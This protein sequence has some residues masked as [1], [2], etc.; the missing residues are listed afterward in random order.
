MRIKSIFSLLV[1][2]L[3]GCT[4]AVAANDTPDTASI[5]GIATFKSNGVNLRQ[6]P[7]AY[8]AYLAYLLS[9][10]QL[11]FDADNVIWSTELGATRVDGQTII[12]PHDKMQAYEGQTMPVIGSEGDW[13]KLRYLGHDVWAMNKFL[14]IQP[15][16]APTTA[17]TAGYGNYNQFCLTGDADGSLAVFYQEGGMDEDPGLLIGKKQGNA[18]VFDYF[19]PI[20][21]QYDPNAKNVEIGKGFEEG[22]YKLTFGPDQRQKDFTDYEVIDIKGFDADNIKSLKGLAQKQAPVVFLTTGTDFIF[23]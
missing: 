13:V 14:T 5:S 2:L 17:T 10:D 20:F 6:E 21:I 9:D 3:I 12:T 23:N 1:T 7:S 18:V 22:Y 16:V 15:V 19:L 8:S 11:Y 4:A